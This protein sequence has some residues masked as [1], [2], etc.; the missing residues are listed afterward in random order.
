[1]REPELHAILGNT[2]NAQ[3]HNGIVIGLSLSFLSKNL[4]K[5]PAFTCLLHHTSAFFAGITTQF[6]EG[7]FKLSKSEAELI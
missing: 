5:V 4:E 3:R 6:T 7:G 1:M 2:M